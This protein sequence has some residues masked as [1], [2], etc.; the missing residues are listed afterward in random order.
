MTIVEKAKKYAMPNYGE[1]DFV[2]KSGKGCYVFDDSGKKYLDF[3][4]GIAVVSLGHA[5]QRW[6][7]AVA[8]QA[9]QIAHC[10]NLY[11]TKANVDLCETL[12]SKI[13]A[14]KVLMCNSGTEANEALIKAAR[15]HG[16][17]VAGKEGKKI[18]IITAVNGFHGRTLGA[19][20]ATA[21]DKIQHGFA[22]LLSG[23]S[24]AEFNNL[25][26]FEKLMGDDVAAILVEPIQ[27][28]SGVTPATKEFLKG[29][30]KL[31]DK[32]N[33]M[34]LFDEVQCGVARSGKFLACQKYGVKPDGVSMAKGLAGG[35]PIGA[36]WLAKDYQDIFT[37]GTHGTTFGGNP[38]ACAAALATLK[39][40]DAKK[41]DVNATNVGE[42]LSKGLKALVKKFPKILKLERGIGLMRAAIFTEE[43]SNVAVCKALREEGLLLIPSGANGLRFLPPLI[44]K[45]VEVK[46]ALK[47]FEKVLER[48]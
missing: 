21:Q 20:A 29:L 37:P 46:K 22:P 10:S 48:L 33:A 24:Y 11:L 3:G 7:K 9:S 16:A 4:S 15:L 38:L 40:I 17:K 18:R 43:Y 42:E 27:G 26:S 5:N 8:Q 35:F 14:G 32:F 25:K 19:V 30:R 6:V 41:L 2:I 28:E 23:F 31:C 47:I 34:L 13:G 39:E 36:V 12:V 45:S 1:R 44:V